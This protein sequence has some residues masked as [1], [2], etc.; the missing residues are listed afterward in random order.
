MSSESSELPAPNRLADIVIRGREPAPPAF[1][2]RQTYYPW[3]VVG[4]TCVAAF[5]GQLDASIV[6]LTLPTLEREFDANL[7]SVSWVAVAYLV[8]FASVLPTFGRLAEM[9]GRKL[10]YVTGV[11]LFTFASLL[12]GFAHTL[13]WLILFRAVQGIGGVLCGANSIAILVKAAGPSRRSRAMGVLAAAQAIGISAGPAVGG[14]LLGTLG[15]HWVFWV[16]VPFGLVAAIW[17]LVVVPQSTDLDKNKSLDWQ[18]AL[19]LTPA[20]IALALA[21]TEVQNWGLTSPSFI[22]CL[23]ISVLLLPLF[24][25][26][27]RKAAAPLLNPSLFG[28]TGFRYGVIA[29]F[30][31]Y[32]LLYGMFFL[33]SF[34]LVRGY[35]E[36]ALTAGLRLAA[37]PVALGVIAPFSGALCVRLGSRILTALGMLVC[38]VSLILL[39]LVLNGTTD[40]LAS[41]M[42][43][44]ALFGVGLGYLSLLTTMQPCT[45]Y[46]RSDPAKLMRWST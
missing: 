25:R 33:M 17:A 13:G 22:A 41:V 11:L 26:R 35:A 19:L 30:L 44:L 18:G 8:G 46:R 29:V 21:L 32:A 40:N 9:L 1:I 27:E 23:I 6:Q 45:P 39:Q 5:I 34:V 42:V 3:L 36:P 31:S 38:V 28:Y 15:W 43:M 2:T 10:L 37:V 4:V 12:C 16:N 7:G 24:I 14:V 20:L